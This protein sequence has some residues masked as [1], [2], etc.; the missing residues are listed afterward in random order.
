MIMPLGTVD[1]WGQVKNLKPKWQLSNGSLGDG[2]LAVILRVTWA[3]QEGSG[4]RLAQVDFNC[5]CMWPHQDSYL[6]TNVGECSIVEGE[7]L[8][9]LD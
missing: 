8:T 5:E 6:S 2:V 9:M 1:D 3:W 7:Y 4:L